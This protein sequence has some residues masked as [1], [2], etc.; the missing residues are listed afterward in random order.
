MS[1]SRHHY[2]D[3]REPLSTCFSNTKGTTEKTKYD[4]K[5]S[6]SRDKDEKNVGPHD[7]LFVVFR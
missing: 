6:V 4:Q 3:K 1:N 7:W 5:S 2:L